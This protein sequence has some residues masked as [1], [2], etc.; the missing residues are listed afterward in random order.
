MR[1]GHTLT[2]AH[3]HLPEAFEV[4]RR[5]LLELG[6]LIEPDLIPA[7]RLPNVTAPRD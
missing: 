6:L 2:G 1:S 3:P 7:H 5:Q 4:L